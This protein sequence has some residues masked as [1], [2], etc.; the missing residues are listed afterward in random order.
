MVV[1]AAV[2]LLMSVSGRCLAGDAATPSAS[3]KSIAQSFTAFWAAAHDQ[4]FVEQQRLWD[5]LIEAP[6]EAL[7]RSVVWETRD[8]PDWQQFKARMLKDRFAAYPGIQAEIPAEADAIEAA[9]ATQS[10]RFTEHF[11]GSWTPR[12]I[13]LLAPNFDAKSGVLADG[14]PVL[15]LAVDSLALEKAQ[16]DIVLPHEF[17]HLWDAE[18]SG[19]TNDGVMPNTRLTLPLFAEGLATYVSTVLSPGYGDGQYLLQNDLGELPDTSEQAIAKRFLADA[20][21]MTLDPVQQR[22]SAG[23]KRW[24]QGARTRW[25]ADLPNRTGYW[26]GLHLIRAMRKSHSLDEIAAWSPERAQQETYA[27]LRR[28]AAGASRN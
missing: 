22:A 21:S 25:Q 12:A 10:A 8:S 5:S 3:A 11:G 9:V 24:F 14:S 18:Y 20:G 17:F 2:A 26:L 6:R 4:P 23:F 1:A 15:V 19:I 16:L 27:T 28:M 13:L 7:Y